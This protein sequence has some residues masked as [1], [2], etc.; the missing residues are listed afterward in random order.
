MPIAVAAIIFA[1]WKGFTFF[2]TEYEYNLGHYSNAE[3]DELDNAAADEL[4]TD[5]AG[6]AE[7]YGKAEQI[8]LDNVGIIPLYQVS[9][10]SLIREGIDVK[11]APF[12]SYVYRYATVN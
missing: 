7:A 2:N 5:P 1:G 9:A 12:G 3:Y 6:R 8:G 11:F 10:A 4:A